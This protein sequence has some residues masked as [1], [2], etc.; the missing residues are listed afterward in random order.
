MTD[1]I[2]STAE[3]WMRRCEKLQV[4]NGV[5]NAFWIQEVQDKRDIINVQSGLID[6][7]WEVVDYYEDESNFYDFMCS[8]GGDVWLSD[9]AHK[10]ARAIKEKY[11]K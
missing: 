5:L 7:L 10:R 3:F 6:E 1:K 8:A 9:D 4:E 11:K 2:E